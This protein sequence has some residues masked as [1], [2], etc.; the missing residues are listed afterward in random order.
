MMLIATCH[1]TMHGSTSNG[2]WI[3][4]AVP[5][6]CPYRAM[7]YITYNVYITYMRCTYM[8]IDITASG[9]TTTYYTT[10]RDGVVDT[11]TMCAYT[12]LQ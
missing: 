10:P 6:Q 8:Y 3:H 2:M 9:H 1:R 4:I 7:Y 5:I 11:N 12:E